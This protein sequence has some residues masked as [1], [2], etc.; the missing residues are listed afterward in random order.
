MIA[1]IAAPSKNRFIARLQYCAGLNLA[2]IQHYVVIGE[3]T[4]TRYS[5]RIG[6]SR[7]RALATSL[8]GLLTL[9]SNAAAYV[10]PRLAQ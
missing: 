10:F 9:G 4:I 2:Q 1:A 5:M 7:P 3:G 6:Q 8:A